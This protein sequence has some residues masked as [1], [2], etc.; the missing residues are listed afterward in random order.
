MAP[1]VDA[2]PLPRVCRP[3]HR[4]AAAPDGRTVRDR[5][6]GGLGSAAADYRLARWMMAWYDLA[7][8]SP[9]SPRS[10]RVGVDPRKS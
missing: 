5:T 10:V 4:A 6:R 1:G 7:D 8:G 9:K 2:R 3:D